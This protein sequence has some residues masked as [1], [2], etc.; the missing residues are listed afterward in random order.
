MSGSSD[1][2]CAPVGGGEG[3]RN[4]TLLGQIVTSGYLEWGAVCRRRH[5]GGRGVSREEWGVD[6]P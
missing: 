2:G 5:E 1:E 4:E 6:D 3:T